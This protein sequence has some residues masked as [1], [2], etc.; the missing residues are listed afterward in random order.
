MCVTT[1]KPLNLQNIN[2]KISHL[3]FQFLW[4]LPHRC[5]CF[6]VLSYTVYQKEVTTL[7]NFQTHIMY[8]YTG[9]YRTSYTTFY[10][11]K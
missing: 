9:K 11:I 3:L 8:P 2:K 5:T 1:K 4:L 6:T 10:F 7:Q